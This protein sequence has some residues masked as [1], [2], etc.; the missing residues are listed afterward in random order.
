MNKDA[1]RSIR[2][3]ENDLV[4]M[5]TQVLDI[6]KPIPS[7]IAANAS[8]SPE[9]VKYA[10]IEGAVRQWIL[11]NFTSYSASRTFSKILLD[12]EKF[13]TN[14]EIFRQGEK[15]MIHEVA[16]RLYGKSD[17]WAYEESDETSETRRIEIVTLKRK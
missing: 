2:G 5:L 6:Q 11:N 15:H 16:D 12:A 8:I 4:R 10:A 3:A 17:F 13:I 7:R 9:E 14:N 1:V